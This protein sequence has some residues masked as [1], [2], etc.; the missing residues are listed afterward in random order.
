MKILLRSHPLCGATQRRPAP[1]VTG[2]PRPHVD[3]AAARARRNPRGAM[4][5]RVRARREIAP[6]VEL[7]VVQ[8]AVPPELVGTFYKNGAGR[9]RLDGARRRRRAAVRPL[10]RRRWVR[11]EAGLNGK[12]R[13]AALRRALRGTPRRRA[14]AS[15]RRAP[16]PRRAA[17]GRREAGSVRENCLRIPTNPRTPTRY[18][19]ATAARARC[20]RCASGPPV[21]PTRARSDAHIAAAV[22]F[23]AARYAARRRRAP[24]FPPRTE[25]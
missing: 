10:V 2:T 7:V 20:S 25:A 11:H 24:S 17:R 12:G 22:A 9:V 5:R 19:S 23:L 14:Q 21:A 8:G 18:S 1:R 4:A 13:A 15:R 6:D 3:H 16:G